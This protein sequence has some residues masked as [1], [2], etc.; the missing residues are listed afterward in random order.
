MAFVENAVE[1]QRPKGVIRIELV[2]RT[3]TATACEALGRRASLE[4]EMPSKREL[5]Y[6]VELDPPTLAIDA[7]EEPV[8]SASE[9]PELVEPVTPK[10]KPDMIELRRFGEN[11]KVTAVSSVAQQCPRDAFGV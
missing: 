2:L 7:D 1:K 8:R 9:G 11:V 5:G 10:Q 3:A 6:E 4:L